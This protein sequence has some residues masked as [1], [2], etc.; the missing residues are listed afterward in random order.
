MTTDPVL[1]MVRVAR[2][3]VHEGAASARA[4]AVVAAAEAMPFAGS[5][6]GLTCRFG[7]MFF[8]DPPRALATLRSTLA[9]GGRGVF[10]VWAER[11]GNP[12]FQE[13]NQAVREMFPDAPVPEPDD[14]HGFRYAAEGALARLLG[15]SG[16]EEV[17]ERRLARADV[18]SASALLLTNALIGAWP[19]RE[20]AG[21]KFGV[22]GAAREFNAWLARQ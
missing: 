12:F 7:A 6:A 15:A 17:A 3:A 20:L 19:V 2:R 5:F 4:A 18:E 22:D 9:P 16:W 14:P 13:V 10:A 8:A 1:E 21:R 11:E